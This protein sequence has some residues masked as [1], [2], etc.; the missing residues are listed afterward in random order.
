MF[1]KGLLLFHTI[2]YL[3]VGQ[4]TNRI[5]RKLIKPK[6]AMLDSLETSIIDNNLKPIIKHKQKMFSASRFSFL[7]KEFNV[8]LAGDWNTASQ[9]KLWIY[10]LHYFDDLNAFGS[11]QR[12]S[13]H[14][15]LIQRWIDENPCGFGMVGRHTPLL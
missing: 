5:K 10:N 4:I 15:N 3:R 12:N 7:N 8:R 13:W 2:K 9:D 11:E 14:Y 1:N 6:V